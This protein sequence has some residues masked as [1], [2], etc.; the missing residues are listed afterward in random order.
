MAYKF[1]GKSVPRLEGAEKVSGK[2]RYAA[3]VDIPDALWAKLCVVPCPTR[4]SSTSILR[5]QR[6]YRECG[7]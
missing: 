7:R 1:V 3:D 5:R 6:N 4:V 2:T